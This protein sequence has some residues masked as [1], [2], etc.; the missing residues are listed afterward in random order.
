MNLKRAVEPS[1]LLGFWFQGFRVSW[2][3]P[4]RGRGR[5]RDRDRYR[6]SG[7]LGFKVSGFLGF[8][9]SRFHPNR[10]RGRDRDRLFHHRTQ[11]PHSLTA[12]PPHRLTTSPPLR[13][14][15]SP[16]SQYVSPAALARTGRR[17]LLPAAGCALFHAV[18]KA[19]I[20]RRAMLM[21]DG[22]GGRHEHPNQSASAISLPSGRI[23]PPSY[24][25]VK[26]IIRLLGS[27]QAWLVA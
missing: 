4:N 11:P 14:R 27:A 2:F 25:A 13:L 7:F 3:H 15:V 9:V 6:V 12:S 21:R 17:S 19:S 16:A 23:S 24:D 20:R 22:I 26:P 5:D 10:G 18:K 1:T 8:R